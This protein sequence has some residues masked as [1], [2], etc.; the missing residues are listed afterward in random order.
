MA[1]SGQRQAR[2][3]CTL[4]LRVDTAP[5][6][7][8]FAPSG[9]DAATAAQIVSEIDLLL[10]GQR[11]NA[12]TTAVISELVATALAGYGVEAATALAQ[13]LFMASAEFHAS[14]IAAPTGSPRLTAASLTSSARAEE[15][16]AI[17]ILNLN[18]GCDSYNT[19][20][21]YDSDMHAHYTEI[22]TVVAIP[23]SELAATTLDARDSLRPQPASTFA[24]HPSLTVVK[25][26]YD[27]GDAAFLANIGNL[28]EPLDA[29][30]YKSGTARAPPQVF[31]HNMA[32]K[33]SHNAHP[34]NTNARSAHP[35]ALRLALL[36]AVG[37]LPAWNAEMREPCLAPP[38]LCEGPLPYHLP[39]GRG[40]LGRVLEALTTQEVGKVAAYS[41]SGNPKILEGIAATPDVISSGGGVVQ[42]QDDHLAPLISRVMSLPTSSIFGETYNALTEAALVRSGLLGDALDAAAMTAT[43]GNAGLSNQFRQ[44]AKAINASKTLENDRGVYYVSIGSFD[45]HGNSGTV[46]ADKFDAIDLALGSFVTEMK[47]QGHWNN[48]AVLCISEFSRTITSNGV[49]TDHGWGGNHFLLGGSVKGGRI[50]GQYPD[51]LS[52][53]NPQSLGR[54]RMIPTIPWEAVYG[55][56]AEWFGVEK[57]RMSTVLPNLAN[58]D[59]VAIACQLSSSSELLRDYP[60]SSEVVGI[61]HPV[62][63]A[64]PDA[65][66][67][68]VA[69]RLAVAAAGFAVATAAPTTP[70]QVAATSTATASTAA[71]IPAPARAA[72]TQRAPCGPRRYAS[73]AATSAGEPSTA[74]VAVA[75]SAAASA[76]VAAAVAPAAWGGKSACPLVHALRRQGR[77]PTA[78]PHLGGRRRR[79]GGVGEELRQR[80][81]RRRRGAGAGQPRLT[82]RPSSATTN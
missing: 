24:V 81:G 38:R 52:D 80:R 79:H 9:G 70:A 20:I 50:F 26:L 73:S 61:P 49:G 41:I 23:R 60:R 77:D 65:A 28:I 15:F 71:A 59:E 75:A 16:K 58:F 2:S 35:N 67:A 1:C 25:Q 40:Y 10:T 3:R 43:W 29:E 7:F 39:Y 17:V 72:A 42:L 45:T 36:N 34:Q 22:R 8:R 32:T 76:A 48:V 62:R 82:D 46:M 4:L 11:L 31:A 13:Q 51:D 6:P 5:L 33:W 14:N 12:N 63:R 74:A 69:P 57:S 56:L 78:R 64:A 18:G 47:A 68:A 21:P 53:A 44:V 19:L 55:P 30:M 54:G 27:E 37:L 66:V